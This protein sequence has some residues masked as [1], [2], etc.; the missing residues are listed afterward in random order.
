MRKSVLRWITVLLIGI[1]L[2]SNV[3]PTVFADD[4]EE[5]ENSPVDFVLVLDC[6]GSLKQTDPNKLCI[7]ATK[8]FL[9]MIPVENARIGIIGFGYP[10]GESYSLNSRIND[11]TMDLDLVQLVSPLISVEDLNEDNKD[12]IKNAASKA[13]AV[14]GDTTPMGAGLVSAVDLLESNGSSDGNACIIV[15]SDGVITSARD[16]YVDEAMAERAADWAGAHRWP[17]YTLQLNDHNAS[18]SH[19][20]TRMQLIAEKSGAGADGYYNLTD[21]S[22][23][24]TDVAYAFLNIFNRFMGNKGNISEETTDESGDVRRVLTIDNLTSETTIVASGNSVKSIQIISPSGA[25]LNPNR[26]DFILNYEPGSYIC[27]KLICPEPG[28]WT[29]VVKGDSNATIIM[30][31]CSM[32]DM[33]MELTSSVP[34][35]S[36]NLISKTETIHFNVIFSYHGKPVKA[37]QEFFEQVDSTLIAEN[38]TTGERT[39]FEDLEANKEGFHK[40]LTLGE[41]GDGSFKFQYRVDDSM[42]RNGSKTSN[43]LTPFKTENIPIKLI[44]T[45]LPNV[46]GWINQPVDKESRFNMEEYVQNLDGDDLEYE[47]VCISDRNFKI[48]WTLDPD[49]YLYI[50]NCGSKPAEYQLQLSVREPSG[51]WLFFDPFILSVEENPFKYEP[52]PDPIEL[53]IDAYSWQTK[54]KTEIE[55]NLEEPYDDEDGNPAEF[56]K[57]EFS[58]IDEYYSVDQDGSKVKIKALKKSEDALSMSFIVSDGVTEIPIEIPIRIV[59]GKQEFWHNNWIW[60]ALGA[61]LFI[62]AILTLIVLNKI[63]RIKGNWDIESERN[64][65][66][67]DAEDICFSTLMVARNKKFPL[68]DL[69]NEISYLMKGDKRAIEGLSKFFLSDMPSSTIEMKGVLGAK[70]FVLQK[71]PDDNNV[72][73]INNGKKAKKH[74]K[75]SGGSLTITVKQEDPFDGNTDELTLRFKPAAWN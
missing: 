33:D 68:L 8:M 75:I 13:T 28:E 29:A 48:D 20:S 56:D 47:L 70:G 63:T 58:G 74:T 57:F 42:F 39:F 22:S 3:V 55:L 49:N 69:L 64:G 73:V 50:N 32:R 7:A 25:E 1:L 59:S 43:V 41:I 46:S 15:L 34:P 36:D 61:L 12:T 4:N 19:V 60:F 9:D 18:P 11:A 27:A 44:K 52:I 30:Y 23:G 31:D 2:L 5:F 53:W 51:E 10:G 54:P 26:G 45:K 65:A 24:K 37:T 6:S 14:D 40:A 16:H 71:I 72:I 35:S 17:V 66:L 38:N 62:M 67:A 21:F